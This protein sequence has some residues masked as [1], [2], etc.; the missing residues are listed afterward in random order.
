MHMSDKEP[1]DIP[2]RL[3]IVG[4]S[5]TSSPAPGQ[6]YSETD[7]KQAKPDER[8]PIKTAI[9]DSPKRK[10]A[11]KQA[12][13]KKTRQQSKPIDKRPVGRPRLF[14]TPEE[15]QTKID[16]YFNECEARQVQIQIEGADGKI[17]CMSVNKPMPYAIAELAY[18][19]G[20]CDRSQFNGYGADHP[21]FSPT[22]KRA[23]TKIEGQRERF[24][25]EP[26]KGCQPVAMI[27]ALKNCHGWRDE[28]QQQLSISEDTLHALWTS[29]ENPKPVWN[30]RKSAKNN[31]PK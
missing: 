1:T 31:L 12:K 7:K 5:I 19:L 27:F 18:H 29:Q 6:A 13:S 23:R 11:K 3:V 22:I 8:Q 30:R 25:A 4:A 14:N 21:E 17:Q 16:D 10:K 20:F 24:L 2:K 15:M 9:P 26:P 28:Q